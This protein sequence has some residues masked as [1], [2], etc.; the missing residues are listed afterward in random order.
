MSSRLH[1]LT[2][3]LLLSAAL[4]AAGASDP[5][6]VAARIPAL[7]ATLWQPGCISTA[8]QET[9][10]ALHPSGRRA[11][12][13]RGDFSST[14][15]TVLEARFDPQEPQRCDLRIVGFSGRWRD[16]EPHLSA[17]G[18][19][20]YFVSNRPISSGGPPVVA[21]WNGRR[22]PG[23]Q[24]WFVPLDADGDA[25]GPAERV[26]G[27]ANTVPMVYNPST[28]AD[29]DL[30]FSSHR[31]DSGPGYQIYRAVWKPQD[32]VHGE[33]E[34]LDLGSVERN[35]MDPAI[36]PD[37][38]LLVYAGDEGDSF[39]AADLYV[40]WHTADGAWSPPLH[41]P[42]PVNSPW[43]ENA[44]G[45]G[46]EAGVLYF[47]SARPATADPAALPAALHSLEALQQSLHDPLNGSRNLWRVDLRA[48][49]KAHATDWPGAQRDKHAPERPLR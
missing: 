23:A 49:L 18:R 15:A 19:R 43:L 25:A 31:P 4:T 38:Q 1:L 27:A 47:S 36:S 22:F 41:L 48:W 9:S 20:L 7:E 30:Y 26:A 14:R 35:R 46:E 8:A 5:P 6:Q 40:V 24:L 33:I 37:G 13:M 3:C 21:E 45:W 34:R 32:G 11:W 2:P 17:D 10:A 44:P 29:G 39:G 28:S 16:S 12:F 42:A